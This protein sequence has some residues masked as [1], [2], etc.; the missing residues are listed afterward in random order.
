MNRIKLEQRGH[1]APSAVVSAPGRPSR[2][3]HDPNQYDRR[4][5]EQAIRNSE[6]GCDG[7]LPVDAQALGAVAEGWDKGS[8]ASIDPEQESVAWV[9]PSDRSWLAEPDLFAPAYDVTA[10]AD[11]SGAAFCAA[12]LDGL[13]SGTHCFEI[14]LDGFGP[15]A[16]QCSAAILG[17]F[18]VKLGARDAKTSRWLIENRRSLQDALDTGGGEHILLAVDETMPDTGGT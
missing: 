2:V 10:G 3:R 14:R 15:I 13:S 12:L 16:V 17:G 6:P 5:F 7:M 11:P 9:V 1:S 8:A 4:H 18:N